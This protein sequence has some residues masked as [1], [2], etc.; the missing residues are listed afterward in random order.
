MLYIIQ[1]DR[2]GIIRENTW[3]VGQPLPHISRPVVTFQADGDELEV[4]LKALRERSAKLPPMPIV[5][6]E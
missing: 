5:E 4:I 1:K 3:H 6:S 2:S